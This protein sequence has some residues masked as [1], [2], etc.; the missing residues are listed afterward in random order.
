MTSKACCRRSKE[1]TKSSKWEIV[2]IEGER[3]WKKEVRGGK[4]AV[5]DGFPKK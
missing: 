2:M 4:R 5:K 1:E 3:E